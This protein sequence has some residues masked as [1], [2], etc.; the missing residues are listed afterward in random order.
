MTA[1]KIEM[2]APAKARRNDAE[3]RVTL[4]AYCPNDAETS[5]LRKAEPEGLLA[6][7]SEGR[8]PAFLSLVP[9]S[10]GRPVQFYRVL[11]AAK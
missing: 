4:F 7:I 11:P 1:L 2:A 10:A 8:V 3:G 5:Y 9:E 6:G